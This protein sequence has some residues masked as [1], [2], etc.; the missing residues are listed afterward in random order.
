MAC[1]EGRERSDYPSVL[2]SPADLEIAREEGVAEHM[3]AEEGSAGD[4]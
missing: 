3:R 2:S 4:E 1:P